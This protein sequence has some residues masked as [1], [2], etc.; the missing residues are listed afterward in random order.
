MKRMTLVM[1]IVVYLLLCFSNVCVANTSINPYELNY[2]Y[3]AD[4]T[5]MSLKTS[6]TPNFMGA[7]LGRISYLK[8]EDVNFGE[9]SAKRVR[10]GIA[11]PSNYSN[12]EFWICID[13]K[14]EDHVVASGI[15]KNNETTDGWTTFLDNT[16]NLETEISGVHDLYIVSPWGPGNYSYIQFENEI[17]EVNE[18]N[19]EMYDADRNITNNFSEA[20]SFKASCNF[21][22]HTDTQTS[23]ALIAI[24][25]DSY[26]NVL[27]RW[28]DRKDNID[29]IISDFSITENIPQNAEK[30]SIFLINSELKVFHSYSTDVE[31]IQAV[32]ESEELEVETVEDVVTVRGDSIPGSKIVLGIFKNEVDKLNKDNIINLML[33]DSDFQSFEYSKSYSLDTGDYLLTTYIKEQDVV[34]K[35]VFRF[36]N[37]NDII[38]ALREFNTVSESEIENTVLAYKDIIGLDISKLEYIEDDSNVYKMLCSGRPYVL[39]NDVISNFYNCVFYQQINES[40]SSQETA[41]IIDNNKLLPIIAK[42]KYYDD[43]TKT[44]LLSSA[45]IN[46]NVA[47]EKIT[48]IQI[49][50][51]YFSNSVIYS[52]F[53]S[54]ES[55]GNIDE[56]I[57]KYHAEIDV[58]ISEYSRMTADARCFICNELINSN[59]E[60]TEDIKQL[61]K[62][63]I[64]SSKEKFPT[65]DFNIKRPDLSNRFMHMF[66][67]VPEQ[68]EEDIEQSQ[69][70][71]ITFNDLDNYEWARE[72]IMSLAHIGVVDGKEEQMYY[73][74]DN[75][76]RSEFIKILIKATG[77]NTN[78]TVSYFSDIPKDS[79]SYPTISTAY[80]LGIVNGY[81][82]GRFGGIDNITKQDA[83][84][85]LYRAAKI[86]GLDIIQKDKHVSFLDYKD[87]SA[88]A[89]EAVTTL[90]K[91]EIVS[92]EEN[93][94]FKPQKLLN[95]AEAAVWIWNMIRGG[96]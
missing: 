70:V 10:L 6:M 1:L 49:F 62:I 29:G 44:K 74:G 3:L 95:R 71:T 57:R 81:E 92:G 84:V 67:I 35:K 60:N 69:P 93:E 20:I 80:V 82:D 15:I 66:S 58:S 22:H 28:I 50:N 19:F 30:L 45:K 91:A 16:I 23:A 43:Y 17:V 86:L 13:G 53:K 38:L 63:L 89:K 76:T 42:S 85:M 4:E 68:K 64:D 55:W 21:L 90:A 46:K 78:D 8:F 11:L 72:G 83:A 7:P 75:I 52:V 31:T 87:V 88:Y 77:I 61:I 65:E 32:E 41:D 2:V 14:T 79:W 96:I 18:A 26:G 54:C 34:N 9:K 51:D 37:P 5:D 40:Q 59:Y 48:D 39:I 27:E 25:H 47:I 33:F 94:F 56:Y 73:P 36:I 24:A 12:R